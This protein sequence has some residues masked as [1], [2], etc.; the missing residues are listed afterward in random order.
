ME[1]L[2]VA[3]VLGSVRNGRFGERVGEWVHKTLLDA[4]VDVELVDLA[5]LTIPRTMDAHP[6]VAAFAGRIGRADAV[7]VV[8]PEYNHSYPGPLKTALDAV[9]DEWHA[10]PVGFVSYGGMAGGLRAVEALRP[11]FA[12]LHTVTVRE[13]V[14]LHN[15]WGPAADPEVDYP[16]TPETAAL[17]RLLRQL[18]WWARALRQA[19]TAEPYPA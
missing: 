11:V 6:D 14:S 7:V 4:D 18:L 15:P 16:G 17:H 8:T 12:E 19:R 9:R 3:V 1:P 10:K 13:T 2:R 5:G